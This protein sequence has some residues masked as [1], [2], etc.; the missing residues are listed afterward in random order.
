MIKKTIYYILAIIKNAAEDDVF[1]TSAQFS[2]YII[3]GAFPFA[4]L[5]ITMLDY[6]SASIYEL[7]Y[8]IKTFIPTNIYNIIINTINASIN[9]YNKSYISVSIVAL[10]ISA[11]SGSVGIIKG[12]NKAYGCCFNNNYLRIRLKG[13]LFT[14]FLIFA[15]QL[16]FLFIIAGDFLIR[17]IQNIRIFTD[18]FVLVINFLRYLLPIL[19]FILIFSVTY[20][21]LPFEKVSSKSVI[22]GAIFSTFG[23]IISSSLFSRYIESKGSYYNNIYGS[24]S[25]FFVLLLWIY[26]SSF[27]FLLGAE[28][29]AFILKENI[30]F[31]RKK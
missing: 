21:F 16:S 10:L 17:L 29:N 12:I 14:L 26:L 13:I 25:G 3:L 20:K 22:P 30:S 28:I 7:L 31:K 19:A 8:F 6:Y 5:L 9:T 1:S 24:L 18:F 15:F 11:S 27:V 23:W 2:Y 4:F